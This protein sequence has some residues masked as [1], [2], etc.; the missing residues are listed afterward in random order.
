M[1]LTALLCTFLAIGSRHFGTDLRVYR[2]AVSAWSKGVN[3]YS[4][5]YTNGLHFTYA[6][7]A[8]V[9]LWPLELA[10][11]PLI[12]WTLWLSTIAACSISTW[13]ILRAEGHQGTRLMWWRAVAWAAAALLILEPARSGLT[14][15]QVEALLMLAILVDALVIPPPYKGIVIGVTSAIKLTPLIFILFLL[16]RDWRSSIRAGASFVAVTALAWL[17]WPKESESF[18]LHD[19]F[20][21]A[22]VGGV[23]YEGNQSWFGVLH[24]P[25]FLHTGSLAPWLVLCVITLLIGTYVSSRSVM[26]GSPVH[27]V[28][29]MALTGL[30]ISPISWTHH[31]VWVLLVPPVLV[32][33]CQPLHRTVR[34]MLWVLVVLAV[35]APYLWLASGVAADLLD[36]S[37]A[38][39]GFASLS[40]WAVSLRFLGGSVPNS[41]L[42]T[43]KRSLTAVSNVPVSRISG[44]VRRLWGLPP[45]AGHGHRRSRI[46]PSPRVGLAAIAPSEFAVRFTTPSEPDPF[47]RVN[48]GDVVGVAARDDDSDAV[49]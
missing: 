12:Q 30:L 18:W 40:C 24:R 17:S 26:L 41:Q 48:G 9:V 42:A 44:M 14:Y 35:L 46:V 31:W 13:L 47:E 15:G 1:A 27:G 6:P 34:G 33:G 21:P 19:V 3:P 11:F 36:D 16:V 22:R 39:W 43:P 32:A 45:I 38:L 20:K 37:L 23:S 4:V 25:P 2:E 8:L 5:N 10:S 28:L 29:A 7:F 49:L